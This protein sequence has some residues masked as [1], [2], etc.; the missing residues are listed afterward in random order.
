MPDRTAAQAGPHRQRD[1]TMLLR[2]AVLFRMGGLIQIASAMVTVSPH[3]PRLGPPL[4]LA[5]AVGAESSVLI[6]YWLRRGRL[7][8]A[9]L[10]VDMMFCVAGLVAGAW[11]SPQQDT[12]TWVFFMYPFTLLAC[13]AIGVGYRQLAA[14]TT[15]TAALAAGYVIASIGIHREPWWNDVPNLISYFAN[16]T[17][18]WLVARQMR[19]SGE[20][21]DVSEAAALARATELATARESARYERMLHDRVL[22]TMEM[23]GKSEWISDLG[24]RTYVRS[25]AAWLRGL[26]A[27]ATDGGSTDLA[28]TLQSIV[29]DQA[30]RGIQVEV[31]S[32]GLRRHGS[33]A[34][35]PAAVVA[36]VGG[37]VREAVT[38]VGK[39]AGVDAAV[40][41]A[42]LDRDGTKLTVSIVDQ[43]RG[44]DP[45]AAQHGPGTGLARSVRQRV[46]QIG[47]TVRVDSAP[48]SGTA[49]ELRIPLNAH[50]AAAEP[51]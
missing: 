9:S 33:A 8:A 38:N 13:I 11:A 27:G 36:A 2:A 39:H 16:S 23:L 49:V 10:T 51:A 21:A 28:T 25:E 40:V 44:F 7:D 48:G 5:A 17:L 35:I 37:A 12:H 30:L 41:R 26:V 46:T 45:L 14:V 32:S 50:R 15:A 4:A 6:G 31:N 18:T 24:I 34:N 43:G 1:D 22:Q 47:G 19:R 20:A 42:A 29:R 3:Y